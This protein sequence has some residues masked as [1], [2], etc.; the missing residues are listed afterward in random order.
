MLQALVEDGQIVARG[1]D[2]EKRLAEGMPAEGHEERSVFWFLASGEKR[3]Y[4][5]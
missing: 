2:G 3:W 5:M 1:S 4:Q